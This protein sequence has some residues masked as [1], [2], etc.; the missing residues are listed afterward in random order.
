MTY[1]L[2]GDLS[3]GLPVLN[4]RRIIAGDNGKALKEWHGHV[5]EFKLFLVVSREPLKFAS[6]AIT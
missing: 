3:R 5:K 6:G 1:Y 4:G 2:G